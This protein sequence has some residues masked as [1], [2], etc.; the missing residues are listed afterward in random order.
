MAQSKDAASPNSTYAKPLGLEVIGSSGTSILQQRKRSRVQNAFKAS[1]IHAEKS[2]KVAQPA[3][4]GMEDGALTLKS[5]LRRTTG[6]A[7]EV[8]KSL[9]TSESLGILR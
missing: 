8:D 3:E 1:K 2:E 4:C 7:S 9:Q 6:G 5:V